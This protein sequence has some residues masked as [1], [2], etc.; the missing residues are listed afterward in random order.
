MQ[1][2]QQQAEV[3]DGNTD[4]RLVRVKE[5]EGISDEE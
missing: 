5:D 3:E 4:K 1:E 2:E